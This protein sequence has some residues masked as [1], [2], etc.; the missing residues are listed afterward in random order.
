[1]AEWFLY[2]P[3]S[4]MGVD[5]LVQRA[6][7]AEASGFDGVAFLD[8]VETPMAPDMPIWEAMTVATWVAAHTE[9]L[10]I[11]HL[12]LCDAFRR[13]ALLAKQ[14][15]TLAEASGGRFELGLGAGS[16][17]DELAK[18]E[19]GTASAV[20]RV[21]AL[22]TTLAKIKR[23]WGQTEGPEPVQVPTP[24]HPIPVLLAGTGPRMLKLV[25]EHADWWNL[26]AT[27]VNELARYLP[28]IGAA[29]P[30]VQQMVAFVRAGDDR[31]AVIDKGRRR[32]GHLGPGF[33]GGGA[34]ELLAYF[35]GLEQAGA[36][37]FYVWF[38]D[39]AAVESIEEFGATVVARAC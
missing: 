30:S 25:A 18:F 16:M 28:A 22:G 37:R 24:S 19:F 14:A 26:P 39:F 35:A 7:A 5:D 31:D 33:V 8:H 27:K 38:A 34:D 29:R 23:Y 15:V 1:M 36:Q 9:R 13:P 12:V 6:R 4:R 21:E 11:G 20:Q 17:P 2:L 32:F 10:R 3:Q